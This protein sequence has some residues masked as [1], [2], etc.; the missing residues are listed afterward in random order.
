[1]EEIVISV[2]AV[3]LVRDSRGRIESVL[4]ALRLAPACRR[5]AE[6]LQAMWQFVADPA[7]P[8][9]QSALALV[10]LIQSIAALPVEGTTAMALRI[11]VTKAFL[12]SRD[13]ARES[14]EDRASDQAMPALGAPIPLRT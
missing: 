6:D 12:E 9:W 7:T 2:N 4:E 14:A 5:L 11:V 13:R 1:M 10:A 8:R 3:K